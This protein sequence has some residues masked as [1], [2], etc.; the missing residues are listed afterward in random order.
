VSASE[1]RTQKQE[2][3]IKYQQ[4]PYDPDIDKVNLNEEI[5]HILMQKPELLKKMG[6]PESW[7]VND[8]EEFSK[9]FGE[10]G[11]EP[12]EM[13]TF[14]AAYSPDKWAEYSEEQQIEIANFATSVKIIDVDPFFSN[15]SV[16]PFRVSRYGIE[17]HDKNE[18]E[19][20][21]ITKTPF[22]IESIGES[23]DSKKDHWVKYKLKYKTNYGKTESK[24]VDPNEI[25]TKEIK[26]LSNMG[27]LITEEDT[28]ILNR[29]VKKY[30]EA[31]PRLPKEDIALK[32]GWYQ[33]DTVLVTGEHLHS[34]N[35]IS[36]VY[37]LTDELKGKYER[38]GN[39]QAWI[40]G[41]EFFR[42]YDIVWFKMLSTV[43]A[44]L[45]KFTTVNSFIENFYGDSTEGKTLSMQ[46]GASLVG[47]PSYEGLIN[48]ARNSA[49]GIEKILEFNTDTPIYF[50]EISN[51]KEFDEYIYMIANGKGKG[52]GTKSL[53]FV[54]GGSWHTIVQTSG[55][56]P[57]TK[58]EKTLTGKKLRVMEIHDPI[59]F[60]A[61]EILEEVKE[62]IKNN[63]GLFM[64]EIIQE[65]LKN[66]HRISSL[67]SQFDMFFDKPFNAFSQRMRSYFI[68]LAIGG[69]ILEN[70][71]R[72]NGIETKCTVD[73]CKKYYQK[74]VVD[75]PI[76]PY[77]ENAL[78][79]VYQWTIR[80]SA[81]FERSIKDFGSSGMI[82]GSFETYGWI[83]KDAILF[84]ETMLKEALEDGQF[85]YPKVLDA[86]KKENILSPKMV[87]K[88]IQT[89]R[90][91]TNINGKHAEGL[92]IKVETLRDKL[93][94]DADIFEGFDN[95]P[96]KSIEEMS[97][98]EA[99][100]YFLNKIKP[101][102]KLVTYSPEEA[103]KE[104]IKTFPD[105]GLMNGHGNII[106]SMELCKKSCR[107]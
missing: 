68:V 6:R 51:N 55:E 10:F 9:G 26:K 71:F 103:A 2:L 89:W 102:L 100:Q 59:P 70:V 98:N 30:L 43:S 46:I 41:T 91:R 99:C 92:R 47:V 52:R 74:I 40:K 69:Y 73:I 78:R 19:Y 8:F 31:S 63:Y 23:L 36:K 105:M 34:G 48:D 93:K 20:K 79:Y 28:K 84:D 56:Y 15:G 87:G 82:K 29:Y 66:K 5:V 38:R 75:D 4:I 35:G 17:I 11:I 37:Q 81:R 42:Q 16:Y 101:E 24:Y 67:Y 49:S 83:T 64:D 106:K 61:P 22:I 88:V 96:E 12:H 97:L 86:W 13:V 80:N 33:N 104:F 18:D 90:F 45:I 53:S 60:L 44:F 85:I 62:A 14:F 107:N 32:N 95:E 21:V 7:I 50:D 94:M 58:D 76:T 27:L 1:I 54:E 3:E 57:L 65:I 72:N 25:L 39:K 77:W